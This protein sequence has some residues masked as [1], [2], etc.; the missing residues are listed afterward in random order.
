MAFEM[1][2]KSIPKNYVIEQIV[3]F[4]KSKKNTKRFPPGIFQNL[5]ITTQNK[6][7]RKTQ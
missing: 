1:G 2:M 7:I 5:F 6:I 4:R 3:E